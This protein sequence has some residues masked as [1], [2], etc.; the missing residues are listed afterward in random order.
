MFL[1]I[2]GFEPTTFWVEVLSKIEVPRDVPDTK[3]P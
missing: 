3:G 1:P 2:L